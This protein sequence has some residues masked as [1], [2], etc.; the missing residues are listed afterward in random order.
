MVLQALCSLDLFWLYSIISR[1]NLFVKVSGASFTALL[2]Y[3]DDIVLAGNCISEIQFVKT[4]LDKKLC[5]K[6]LGHLRFFLGLEI[7]RSKSGIL[8]NQRKYTLELLEYAGTLDS[9]SAATPFDPSAKLAATKGTPLTDA[10]S[11]RRLIGK[12]LY[13]TNSRPNI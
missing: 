3:V 11:Y 10:S 1:Y 12:L 13:L 7:A 4:F 8:L 2:V 6:D 5:I 9:K